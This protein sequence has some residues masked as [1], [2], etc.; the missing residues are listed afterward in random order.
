M[1]APVPADLVLVPGLN[2]TAAVWDT[3]RPRLPE[4]IRVHTPEVPALEDIDAIAEAM[5]ATL[6]AR[7]ALVG[8]SFGGYV[9]LAMLAAAP[10]RIG[11]L[12]MVGTSASADGEA[13]RATRRAAIER[14][15]AGEYEAMI[16]AQAARAMGE[17]GRADPAIVAA[18]RAMVRDYGPR[19]FVAHVRATMGRPDRSAL[20]AAYDGPLLVTGGADD[21]VITPAVQ[22]GLA[23]LNPR[24]RYEPIPE[25]G[26]L[27][28]MEQPAALARVLGPWL[29]GDAQP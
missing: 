29:L 2:N 3:V 19:R 16:E 21:Q 4:G 25:A 10:R 7:F 9:A 14:A 28:P 8:F 22:R 18:R 17:A 26:H 13:A 20:F 24:A 15:L 11:A 6:P 23:A 27:V 12:A 1:T 5:L